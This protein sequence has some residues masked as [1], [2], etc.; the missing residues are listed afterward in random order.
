[1]NVIE[2]DSPML[3]GS[4]FLQAE[5]TSLQTTASQKRNIISL[6]NTSSLLYL[7]TAN[8]LKQN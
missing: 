8:I 2:D 7:T 4:S 6:K 5:N 3:C 1:L